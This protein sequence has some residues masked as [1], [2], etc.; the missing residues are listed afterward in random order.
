[1]TDKEKFQNTRLGG[2]N[3][4]RRPQKNVGVGANSKNVTRDTTI[5]SE[6][7]APARTYSIRAREDASSP[8][9]IT[10]FEERSEAYL[11]F[12]MNTKE[13]ELKV[14]LV[15]IVSEY[16]DVFPEELL[17]LPP[18][19]EVEFGIELTPGTTPISIA[20][21]QMAMTE[22]KKLKTRLQELA[23]KDYQQLNKRTIK[24]RCSLARINDLFD[25]MKGA[26]WFSKIDL[27]SGYYQL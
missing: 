19:R 12:V 27:R 23:D 17:G 13:S 9:V 6:A 8:D 26:A 1:M 22:L 21:Y 2:T 5:R 15:P 11:A 25:Q 10:M 14:E 7:R 3:F 4:K 16:L 20:P 24:N 18:N